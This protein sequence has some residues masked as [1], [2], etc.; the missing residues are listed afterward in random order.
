ML[1][2]N[3]GNFSTNT[4]NYGAADV[5]FKSRQ[6][7]L[8]LSVPAIAP[9]PPARLEEYEAGG[10]IPND[11][12]GRSARGSV[13]RRRVPSSRQVCDTSV[14]QADIGTSTFFDA[15]SSNSAT[16]TSSIRTGTE[17]VHLRQLD[18]N[19]H[20]YN[21]QQSLTPTTPSSATRRMPVTSACARAQRG[22]SRLRSPEPP[23]PPPAAAGAAFRTRSSPAATRWSGDG[24]RR[25]LRRCTRTP[26]C[27]TA[28]SPEPDTKRQHPGFY[29]AA[30]V[31]STASTAHETNWLQRGR[32]LRAASGAPSACALV[33]GRPTSQ[34]WA[35]TSSP[36]AECEAYHAY[37]D[38]TTDYPLLHAFQTCTTSAVWRL[39]ATSTCPA[40]STPSSTSGGATKPRPLRR[41]RPRPPRRRRDPSCPA[42]PAPPPPATVV[43]ANAELLLVKAA[44]A[45]VHHGVRR[46]RQPAVRRRRR[47]R[48]LGRP[49]AT[50]QHALG[51]QPVHVVQPVRRHG[52][53]CRRNTRPTNSYLEP[54]RHLIAAT[55]RRLPLLS[56]APATAGSTLLPVETPA[57][58]ER[59]LIMGH[60][61][62]RAGRRS[63]AQA[64][65]RRH[66][67]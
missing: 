15:R 42:F 63:T 45:V 54:P 37:M 59:Q 28:S 49:S 26:A 44:A 14:Q 39:A 53:I 47:S 61:H 33:D 55:W 48:R 38:A 35:T 34:P 19:K 57:D 18:Q 5:V 52:N 62:A 22:A 60:A 64:R 2:H 9:P 16:A 8:R 41:I 13:V 40:D 29:T 6:F 56:V 30:P 21:W 12:R 24:S 20:Y 3:N 50:Q 67:P 43:R 1:K 58:A 7:R 10:T 17:T 65:R 23:L 66:R 51:Q 32:R 31:P 27:I 11:R 46:K 25:P 36:K 4:N